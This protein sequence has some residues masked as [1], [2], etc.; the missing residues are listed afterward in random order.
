[1]T[2]VLITQ[3]GIAREAAMT[4]REFETALAETGLPRESVRRLTRLFEDVRYGTMMPGRR[5]ELVAVDCLTDIVEA[6]GDTP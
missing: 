6:C 4:P 3:K 1:M 5:E 2:R